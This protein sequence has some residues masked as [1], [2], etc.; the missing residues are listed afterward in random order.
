[1]VRE[2]EPVVAEVWPLGGRPAPQRRASHQH[3]KKE[4]LVEDDSTKADVDVVTSFS[5]GPKSM[6][7]HWKQALFLLKEPFIVDEGMLSISLYLFPII[8][9]TRFFRFCCTG[10][11]SLP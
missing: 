8:A 6:A 3:S 11:L 1:M 7:T 5:T 2:N 10:A 4:K 9:L